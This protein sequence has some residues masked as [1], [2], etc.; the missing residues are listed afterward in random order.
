MGERIRCFMLRPT[1]RARVALRRIGWINEGEPECPIVGI[2]AHVARL[3]I[4]I[5]TYPLDEVL[6]G[7]QRGG[8][9][10]LATPD[11]MRDGRWPMKCECD[12]AFKADDEW[13]VDRTRIY[14]S[15]D[16][17]E[18]LLSE[19]PPGAMWYADWYPETMRGPDGHTLVVSCPPSGSGNHWIVDV[20]RPNRVWTRLGDPPN[21]TVHPSI[22]FTSEANE[23]ASA[24][25]GWLR[26]GYL[27]EC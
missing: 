26:G 10:R 14:A 27:E 8:D 12:Y 19:A 13:R 5:E 25:H 16:G 15:D 11:D 18:C 20:S 4:G 24:Y 3:E 7:R 1:E 21:I 2:C 23:G 9:D 17:L 6:P 22:M